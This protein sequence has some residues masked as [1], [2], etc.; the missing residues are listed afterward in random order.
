MLAIDDL[1][2]APDIPDRMNLAAHVLYAGGAP[3]DKLALVVLSASGAERWSYGRLRQ[4]VLATAGGLCAAGLEPGARL[5]MRLGNSPDF[6]VVYLGAISAGLV[7]VPTSSA[8]GVA[9]ISKIA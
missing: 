2:P 3:D 5:L 7:P 6:P 4:R 8:L 1:R 9:E